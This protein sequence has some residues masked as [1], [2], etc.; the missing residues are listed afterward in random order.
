VAIHKRHVNLQLVRTADLSSLC[1]ALKAS[2]LSTLVQ[3]KGVIHVLIAANSQEPK[4]VQVVPL[5]S[6]CVLKPPT[7]T[8][9]CSKCKNLSAMPER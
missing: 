1:S 8:K 2:T 5:L 3:A 4:E 9:E 6:K 7:P